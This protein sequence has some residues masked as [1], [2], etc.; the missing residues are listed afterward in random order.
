MSRMWVVLG[1]STS[2]GG[3]V[4]SGSP[5]TDIDG[6]PVARINDKATCPQHKGT[7]PIADGDPTTIIDGQPAAL[8]GSKLA[9]GC[10][11]LAVQQT[12]VL[13]DSGDGRVLDRGDVS[14]ASTG[15]AAHV[16]DEIGAFQYDEAFILRAADGVPQTNRRYRICR[17]DGA[18][19][20]GTTDSD[21]MT[22]LLASSQSEV[23]LIE[24]AEEGP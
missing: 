20:Y 21:G 12:R 15:N 13:L 24:A 4:V 11:V 5:F 16:T 17:E 18:V 6:K 7:F 14:G 19:E 8:H 22:H 9:C 1:D 2:S 3:S 10:S 23:L